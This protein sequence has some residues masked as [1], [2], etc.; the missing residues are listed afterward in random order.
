MVTIMDNSGP[1]DGVQTRRRQGV[2]VWAA[3]A[4]AELLALLCMA[5]YRSC[6]DGKP[7]TRTAQFS[8]PAL[9]L[10]DP[11]YVVDGIELTHLFFTFQVSARGSDY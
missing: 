10:D 9:V 11:K 7:I 1:D 4:D 2:N 3:R 8:G 6:A 5:V